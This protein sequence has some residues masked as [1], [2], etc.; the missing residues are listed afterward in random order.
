MGPKR[1]IKKDRDSVEKFV[2]E[3][4]SAFTAESLKNALKYSD[5]SEQQHY[6]Q[7]LKNIL[8]S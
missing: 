1:H 3:N 5:R 2:K 6:A 4:L 7:R 8:K